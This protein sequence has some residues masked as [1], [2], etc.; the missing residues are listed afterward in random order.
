MDADA[1]RVVKFAQRL[2]ALPL[3]KKQVLVVEVFQNQRRRDHKW[4]RKYLGDIPTF[5]CRDGSISCDRFPKHLPPPPGYVWSDRWRPCLTGPCDE[6]GWAYAA[7]FDH[8]VHVHDTSTSARDSDC[9]RR[10][11]WVRTLECSLL[12]FPWKGERLGV[13]LVEPPDLARQKCVQVLSMTPL[14]M[15]LLPVGATRA[16]AVKYVSKEDL[17]AHAVLSKGDL[18]LRVNDVDVSAMPFHDVVSALEAAFEAGSMC[19]LRFAAASGHIRI[20]A[21][22]RAARKC[23]LAPGFRLV[24]LN[25]RSVKH[26]RLL[27]VECILRQAPRNACVLHFHQTDNDQHRLPPPFVVVHRNV[28]SVK[29]RALLSPR[30]RGSATTVFGWGACSATTTTTSASHKW[31]SL[32]SRVSALFALSS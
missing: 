28:L 30:P 19:F 10:R 32:G 8:L 29:E 31:L 4:H 14:P 17:R 12:A 15:Y 1:R 18:L 23:N 3:L 21:V 16:A 26:L 9:V 2:N 24:G 25:G 5:S 11:R 7:A 6:N 22:T 13:S 27:D 20:H